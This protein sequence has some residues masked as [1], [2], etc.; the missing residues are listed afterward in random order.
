MQLYCKRVGSPQKVIIEPQNV[1]IEPQNVIIEPQN[2]IIEPQKVIIDP[3]NVIIEPQKVIIEKADD[4]S[5]GY[6]CER[7]YKLFTTL[8]SLKRHEPI[9]KEISNPLQCHICNKVFT[10]AS[11]KSR[12]L[13]SCKIEFIKKE[14]SRI[15]EPPQPVAPQS[16]NQINNNITINTQNTNNN[17]T[18]NVN[19]NNFGEESLDHITQDML[20]KFAKEINCGIAKLID[21]IHFNPEVPQNHNIRLEN[22]KGQLVAVYQ[23]NEW[24]IKDMNDT[25]KHLINNGCRLLTDHYY[26]S[27]ELQKEDNHQHFGVI[28]KHLC[29]VN[30]K[31]KSVYFPT[32][33]LVI[34]SLHNQKRQKNLGKCI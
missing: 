5:H 14:N 12:H 3:Q 23:N 22:I 10:H 15:Q 25:V 8:W 32:R 16:S 6:R 33:R 31:E 7:C 19:L 17:I 9:C 29:G 30:C 21:T 34:A 27:E 2:V 18:I 4:A 26:N 11:N 20:T 24:V 28:Y 13:Q 1:I